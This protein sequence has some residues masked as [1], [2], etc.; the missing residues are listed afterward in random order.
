MTFPFPDY[1]IAQAVRLPHPHLSNATLGRDRIPVS[2]L[3]D[4]AYLFGCNPEQILGW[5][6]DGNDTSDLTAELPCIE[7]GIDTDLPDSPPWVVYKLRNV[8]PRPYVDGQD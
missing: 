2:Y 1:V 5:C 3:I 8:R 4:L 6:D 7:S